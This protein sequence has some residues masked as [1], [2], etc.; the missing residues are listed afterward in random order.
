MEPG[1][2]LAGGGQLPTESSGCKITGNG[3]LWEKNRA[4][5][6][7][8]GQPTCGKGLCGPDGAG[9]GVKRGS[10]VAVDRGNPSPVGASLL[11]R[12]AWRRGA[13]PRP[14]TGAGG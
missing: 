14:S 13:Q 9:V 4:R 7:A 3:F 5:L 10:R 1:L 11:L 8:T 2:G 12:K 6:D